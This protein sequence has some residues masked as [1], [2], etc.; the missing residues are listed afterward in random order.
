MIK[1]ERIPWLLGT[2]VVAMLCASLGNAQVRSLQTTLPAATTAPAEFGTTDYVYTAISGLSFNGQ[3]FGTGPELSRQ[4][5]LNVDTHFY[6]T[7]DIPVGTV[8]DYIGLDNLNDGTPAIMGIALYENGNL[9]AGISS[10]PHTYFALDYNT[11]PIGFPY[12]GNAIERPYLVLDIEVAPSPNIMY[13]LGAQVVWRR[14]VSPAPGTASFNDVPTSHPF[15]QYVEALKASGITGGC[16]AAPPLYCPDN[17][18]TRGQMAVFLAKA[19]GLH[20]PY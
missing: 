12:D 20:W 18:V 5:P 1:S 6:A 2:S 3:S 8:I 9:V 7:L 15:F 16:Q 4:P 11:T 13:F 19:L 14:T 10:T 17:P